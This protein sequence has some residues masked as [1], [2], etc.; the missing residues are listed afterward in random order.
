[1]LIH[2]A[3][4]YKNVEGSKVFQSVWASAEEGQDFINRI[5]DFVCRDRVEGERGKH[6]ARLERESRREIEGI[7]AF[8]V[9]K[10]GTE[11]VADARGAW[12]NDDKHREMG[13]AQVTGGEGFREFG[14]GRGEEDGYKIKG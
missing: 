3:F 12:S 6:L 10:F 7:I 11:P 5:Q 2:R 4:R 9:D 14:G 1:M 13:Q 8:C